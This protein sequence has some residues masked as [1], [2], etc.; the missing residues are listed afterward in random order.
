M[1]VLLCA[2]LASAL[3]LGIAHS[4]KCYTC[5]ATTNLANC[6]TTTTNC[7]SASAYCM[8][9]Q[10]TS[11]GV[12][13]VAKN[14]KVACKESTGTVSGVPTSIHCCST[15]LCNGGT[16]ARV[17]YTMLTLAAGACAL[18]LRAGL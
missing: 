18:L 6:R 8:T 7:S 10:A 9:V 3:L 17:S 5:E 14:C 13:A 1:K 4:L 11:V 15:D 16:S 12:T 2:L